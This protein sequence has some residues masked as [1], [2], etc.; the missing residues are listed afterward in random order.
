[1]ARRNAALPRGLASATGVFADR[2]EN[3]EIWDIEGR[4]FIDFAGGI[5]VLNTGHRHPKVMA[6]VQEQSERFTHTAFQVMGYDSYVEL[7][8]RLNEK[9]PIANAKTLLMSSGAEAIENA[10]KIARFHT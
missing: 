9:A 5:A 3:A 8:E 7:A 10:I 4:R 6:K 1:M 2:A